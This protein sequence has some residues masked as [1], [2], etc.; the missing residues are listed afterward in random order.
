MNLSAKISLY[1]IC[2]LAF[3]IAL[4]TFLSNAKFRSLQEEVERSR[5]TTLALEARAIAER[6]L[7]LGLDL[8]NMSNLVPVPERIAQRHG[9][10]LAVRIVDDQGE[11]LFGFGAPV[12]PQAVLAALRLM[13]AGATSDIG[14]T[15]RDVPGETA[16][17][18]MAPLVN[19]FGR[20]VGAVVLHYDR[21]ATDT[22]IREMTRE[23]ILAALV[24]FFIGSLIAY[25]AVALLMRPTT[26]RFVRLA[27][28][29]EGREPLEAFG[30]ASPA[31]PLESRFVA[32]RR[33]VEETDDLL[34]RAE[35][36]AA[37]K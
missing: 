16:F 35:R 30:A 28:V 23:Q 14:A 37:A 26:N 22:A 13:R 24:A 19:S 8:E 4:L 31:Q 36:L 3:A 7:A 2:L 11:E 27:R 5:Y 6:G 18:V 9:D 17:G 32:A 20:P 12:E 33:R 34:G 1:V 10:I 15:V 21:S 29:A 25:I